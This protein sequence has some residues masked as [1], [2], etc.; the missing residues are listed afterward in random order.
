MGCGVETAIETL[1]SRFCHFYIAH[2]VGHDAIAG[3][4]AG[5]AG[6]DSAD[7]F[8]LVFAEDHVAAASGFYGGGVEGFEKA[9][10]AA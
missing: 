1:P 2:E 5:V 6:F 9:G 10:I 3:Y 4:E 8:C 7:E